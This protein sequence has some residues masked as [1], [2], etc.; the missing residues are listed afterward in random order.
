MYRIV[1][2]TVFGPVNVNVVPE[3]LAAH[4]AAAIAAVAPTGLHEHE[5]PDGRPVTVAVLGVPDVSATE[6]QAA[7]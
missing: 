2:V 1:V 3:T 7:A 5:R 4:P 6:P